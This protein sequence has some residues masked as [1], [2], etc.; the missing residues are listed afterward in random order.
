MKKTTRRVAV[1]VWVAICTILSSH[2]LLAN[3][4]LFPEFL[5]PA[6]QWLILD[7]Y[8]AQ[9]QEEVADIEGWIALAIGLILTS[10]VTWFAIK[11][12]RRLRGPRPST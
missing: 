11:I 1:A 3:P 12:W 7:L 9:N 4:Q 10:L 6:A 8:D 5:K 2:L